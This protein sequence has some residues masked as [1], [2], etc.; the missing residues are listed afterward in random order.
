MRSKL[1]GPSRHVARTGFASRG[2]IV[3]DR[4]AVMSTESTEQF[5]ATSYRENLY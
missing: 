5:V 1:W 2:R 3:A 4:T